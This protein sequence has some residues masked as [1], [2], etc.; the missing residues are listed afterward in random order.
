VIEIP[1]DFTFIW[2]ADPLCASGGLRHKWHV[3]ARD[4]WADWYETV[5]EGRKIMAKRAKREVIPEVCY[6]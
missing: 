1:P 2:C 5:Q 6:S 4:E 3:F